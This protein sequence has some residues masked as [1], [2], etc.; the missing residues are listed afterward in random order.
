MVRAEPRATLSSEM[1]RDLLNGNA[2]AGSIGRESEDQLPP[3]TDPPFRIT[4]IG[5]ACI[6]LVM[7]WRNCLATLTRDPLLYEESAVDE[8]YTLRFTLNQKSNGGSIQKVDILQIEFWQV[9]ALFNFCLQLREISLL[10][11]AA[12]LK[13][14]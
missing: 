8:L 3:A 7:A 10:N 6:L 9:Y 11:S 12:Q 14:G 4:A 2:R 1:G 5:G 13:D